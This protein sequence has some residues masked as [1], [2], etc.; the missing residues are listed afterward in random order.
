MQTRQPH[1]SRKVYACITYSN[2]VCAGDVLLSP[3]IV[4]SIFHF[5]R[6]LL[7]RVN[8]RDRLDETLAQCAEWSEFVFHSFIGSLTYFTAV[9][10]YQA[11]LAR[12]APIHYCSNLFI[13][14]SLQAD[15]VITSQPKYIC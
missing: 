13:A 9:L 7:L 14:L 10:G 12:A 3:M 8:Q 15:D 2:R 4:Y 6:S 5:W 11:Y 1:Y